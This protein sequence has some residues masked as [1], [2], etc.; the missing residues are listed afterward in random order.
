M[1]QA[2][3]LA[4]VAAEWLTQWLVET[5]SFVKAAGFPIGST[6]IN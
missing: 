4:T 2:G 5:L 6:T 1:V 3:V